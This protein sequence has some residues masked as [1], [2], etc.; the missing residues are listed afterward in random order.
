MGTAFPAAFE[1]E[2]GKGTHLIQADGQS[3]GTYLIY[4]TLNSRGK[5]AG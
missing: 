2:S 1:C 5:A 3:L 4:N